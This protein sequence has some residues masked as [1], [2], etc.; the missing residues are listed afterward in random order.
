M[1]CETPPEVLPRLKQY[2]QEGKVLYIWKACVQ[3]A[4]PGYRVVDAP[5][6]L[7]LV[8]RTEISEGN[9]NDTSFPKYVFSLTPIEMVPQYEMR[10][11]R[12]LGNKSINSQIYFLNSISSTMFVEYT[13][14]APH[15]FKCHNLHTLMQ[16]SLGK[17]LPSQMQPL[18]VTHL[19]NLSCEG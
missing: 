1:Y 19:E 2:L 11:D 16:M 5:Y 18:R 3:R 8:M 6:M 15:L 14:N 13:I 7:K 10:T 9:S 17:S 12:F 4:K